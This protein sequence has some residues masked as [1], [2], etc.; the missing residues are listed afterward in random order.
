M[1]EP[2]PPVARN[3]A[4]VLIFIVG[5]GA[6]VSSLIHDLLGNDA[7]GSV[8]NVLILLLAYFPGV[9]AV[10]VAAFV[11]AF[12]T[13]RWTS[14]VGGGRW[15]KAALCA[16]S[17]LNAASQIAFIGYLTD[18]AAHF[19]SAQEVQVTISIATVLVGLVAA[20]F[21]FR[22]NVAKGFARFSLFVAVIAFAATEVL[23]TVGSTDTGGFWD[24]PRLAGVALLGISYWR[25]GIV[26]RLE[27]AVE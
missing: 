3:W 8:F 19:A 6:L 2:T 5:G 27:P 12:G 13:A 11:L 4:G 18:D 16:W 25:A 24:L 23:I 21:I 1:T 26:P 17:V 7:A 15:G 22:A 14:I 9:I 20:T 10:L